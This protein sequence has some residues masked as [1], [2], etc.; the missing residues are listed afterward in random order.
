VTL[1]AGDRCAS[2]PV[3]DDGGIRQT[4]LS[5]L[6]TKPLGVIGN[7]ALGPSSAANLSGARVSALL[8]S[9]ELGP[10]STPGNRVGTECDLGEA[11]AKVSDARGPD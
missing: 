5:A 1:G 8:R 4:Q 9:S 10:I 3:S 7:G 6:G 2:Y 11:A